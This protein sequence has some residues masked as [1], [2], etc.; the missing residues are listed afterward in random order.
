MPCVRLGSGHDQ[1]TRHETEAE[2]GSSLPGIAQ[3][4]PGRGWGR[5]ARILGQFSRSTR[6]RSTKTPWA[7]GRHCGS[8]LI[9]TV[10]I[11]SVKLSPVTNSPDTSEESLTRLETVLLSTCSP[12]QEYI[13]LNEKLYKYHLFLD[14]L[15]GNIAVVDRVSSY[16]RTEDG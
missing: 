4:R 13:Y 2:L 5:P 11:P 8:S 16:S 9:Q 15:T 1:P 3:V 12:Q 6:L 14:I 7:L 10:G